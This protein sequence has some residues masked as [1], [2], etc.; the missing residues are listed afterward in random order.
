MEISNLTYSETAS[1]DD[2]KHNDA[3]FYSADGGYTDIRVDA[4]LDDI[5]DDYYSIKDGKEETL[6]PEND[7]YYAI[8]DNAS[9]EYNK[10]TFRPKSIP[11]DPSYVHTLRATNIKDKTYDH[12]DGKEC[13]NTVMQVDDYSHLNQNNDHACNNMKYNPVGEALKGDGAAVD[14]NEEGDGYTLDHK[15]F[16]LEMNK[17]L[18][19]TGE[20][21]ENEMSHG[22]FVLEKEGSSKMDFIDG[23]DVNKKR[24]KI[25][26]AATVQESDPSVSSADNVY[27]QNC[28]QADAESDCHK[29]QALELHTS[30]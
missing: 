3:Q 27:F 2:V 9:Q 20:D 5:N 24:I 28:R 8:K 25:N 4:T 17:Y 30:G 14:I 26:T 10:I 21:K 13:L 23:N 12:V 18:R 29:Y 16:T 11:K 6:Q 15:Y 1:K 22:Y 19:Q 7:N